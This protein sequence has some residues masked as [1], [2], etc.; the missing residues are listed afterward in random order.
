MLKFRRGR[1]PVVLISTT[2][3]ST[4]PH[5]IKTPRSGPES[6][7]LHRFRRRVSDKST[8]YLGNTP[9]I[10]GKCHLLMQ[11]SSVFLGGS[12]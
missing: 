9:G 8:L 2:K 6:L 1:I 12:S 3:A 10:I 4:D 5:E 7:V 11:H